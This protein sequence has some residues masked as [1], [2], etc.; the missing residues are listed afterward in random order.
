[1]RVFPVNRRTLRTA[2]L[3][4]AAL[5]AAV[6]LDLTVLSSDQPDETAAP[7]TTPG[8]L[9]VDVTIPGSAS[10]EATTDAQSAVA[11]AAGIELSAPSGGF[12]GSGAAGAPAGV[13]PTPVAPS[14]PIPQS[15]FSTPAPP[16]SPATTSPRAPIATTTTRPAPAATTSTT[17][18]PPPPPATT[19]Q[20]AS[21]QGIGD[22]VV[23][24]TNGRLEFWSCTPAAGWGYLVEKNGPSTV[25]VKFR[26]TSGEGEAKIEIIR[27]S[28]G[29]LLI[30]REN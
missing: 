1:M 7:T 3:L 11:T 6:W 29:S 2:V 13:S 8:Q 18:A 9:F 27:R 5:G 19:F 24:T 10:S 23:A 21:Y 4:F 16:R 25:E 15:S 26:R 12:A 30:K 28:D 20:T 14:A 17:Q 22:V